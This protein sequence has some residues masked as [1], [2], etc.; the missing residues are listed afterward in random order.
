MVREGLPGGTLGN[1]S[2]FHLKKKTGFLTV[3]FT[4]RALLLNK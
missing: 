3:W 1:L 2:N 4:Y